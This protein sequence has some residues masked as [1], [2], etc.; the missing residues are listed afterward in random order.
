MGVRIMVAAVA[1]AALVTGGSAASAGGGEP[2]RVVAAAAAVKRVPNEVGKNHQTA[3]NHL[4]SRGFTNLRERDC[5]GRGRALLFDRN[6]KVVRQSP[7]A[8]TR[9]NTKRRVTLCSVKYSD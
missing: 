8:G 6:W 4:Q 7:P 9:L 3:Q 2:T 5:T 1:T